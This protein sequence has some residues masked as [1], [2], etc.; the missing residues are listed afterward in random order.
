[1]GTPPLRGEDPPAESEDHHE[2]VELAQEDEVTENT[3]PKAPP[4]ETIAP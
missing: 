4:P 1:M 3:L 2:R